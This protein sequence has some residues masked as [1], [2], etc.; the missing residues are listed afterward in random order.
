MSESGLTTVDRPDVVP[1]MPDPPLGGS[2]ATGV[3]AGVLGWVEDGVLSGK[4]LG[5][6]S[7][8]GIRV[9]TSQGKGKGHCGGCGYAKTELGQET[10]SRLAA[11]YGF[12]RFN[13]HNKHLLK[14]TRRPCA[15]WNVL[16]DSMQHRHSSYFTWW[17]GFCN[18]RDGIT[19]CFLQLVYRLTGVF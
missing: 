2:S 12:G 19:I 3:S 10:P 11:C 13:T 8:S 18:C 9:A 1:Y 6:R 14:F 4:F 16:A 17:A 7:G 15:S 5:C